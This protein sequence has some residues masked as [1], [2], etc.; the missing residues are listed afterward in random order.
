MDPG[1]VRARSVAKVGGLADKVLN[2]LEEAEL[3]GGQNADMELFVGIARTFAWWVIM[4]YE[5][6]LVEDG[7]TS[8]LV[9]IMVGVT[10]TFCLSSGLH[11]F[12]MIVYL[13]LTLPWMF[14]STLHSNSTKTRRHRSV[15]GETSPD[16]QTNLSRRFPRYYPSSNLDV[17]PPL[18][19]T[20]PWS[21]HPLCLFRMVSGLLGCGIRCRCHDRVITS[22]SALSPVYHADIRLTLSIRRPVKMKSKTMPKHQGG[23]GFLDVG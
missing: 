16:H 6:M 19:P 8:P 12:F 22:S 2:P 3:V 9:I 13:I 17:L 21:L 15:D 18:C 7:S 14:L 23:Y 10:L 11:D 20:Y 5:L 4:R 1:N